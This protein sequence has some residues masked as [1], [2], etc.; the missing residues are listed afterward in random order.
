MGADANDSAGPPRPSPKAGAVAFIPL[1]LTRRG[2]DA[3]EQ[4]RELRKRAACQE[5]LKQIDQDQESFHKSENG[6][7]QTASFR[8]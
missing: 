4:R 5:P 7:H 6:P 2:P 8:P 3:I 1:P